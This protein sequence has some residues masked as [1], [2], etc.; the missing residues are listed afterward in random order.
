VTLART[1]CCQCACPETLTLEI[2]GS[3]PVAVA[4]PSNVPTTP[5]F[6]GTGRYWNSVG[7]IDD[8][9]E[10]INIAEQGIG[11]NRPCYFA[12]F[13]RWCP[14][15]SGASTWPVIQ[16][17]TLSVTRNLCAGFPS[18]S[19][20]CGSQ[21]GSPPTTLN[22]AIAGH[23]SLRY[24]S[25]YDSLNARHFISLQVLLPTWDYVN[26]PWYFSTI[27]VR[28]YKP[29]G[30]R[31]CF[32]Q[33]KWN[34]FNTTNANTHGWVEKH[35]TSFNNSTGLEVYTTT[36]RSIVNPPFEIWVT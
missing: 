33:G 8:Q 29:S 3:L 11:Q 2:R 10:T 32:P 6:V 34:L 20:P 1:C 30:S 27:D 17:W 26:Q 14:S 16:D 7:S 5:P 18:G 13:A 25:G 9:I 22:G 19:G 35:I 23:A 4:C 21:F 24:F 31:R 36:L 12:E 15:T 28:A